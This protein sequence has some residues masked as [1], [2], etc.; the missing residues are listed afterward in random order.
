MTT[1]KLPPSAEYLVLKWDDP[2]AVGAILTFADAVQDK[3][4]KLAAELRQ[5]LGYQVPPTAS[6]EDLQEI[7]QFIQK[8]ASYLFPADANT[9]MG[10]CQALIS[11]IRSWRYGI[12]KAE[13]FKCQMAKDEYQKA[14]K[15]GRFHDENYIG[16]AMEM[17]CQYGAIHVDNE[18][19][20]LQ[21]DAKNLLV[22]M[23]VLGWAPLN[24][25]GQYFAYGPDAGFTLF[26]TE[27]EAQ[28]AAKKDM[29]TYRGNAEGEG[30]WAEEIEAVCWG[31]VI[32]RSVEIPIEQDG[33]QYL[34]YQLEKF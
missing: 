26:A 19:E 13:S 6:T 2:N 29:D 16:Y 14:E 31:R 5:K 9:L 28:A 12:L 32:E 22:M 15:A 30:E 18:G 10:F 7:E 25:K 27:A 33:I 3:N 1:D 4:P 17:A 20:I 34:D 11:E 23:L 8:R 24:Q 21:I